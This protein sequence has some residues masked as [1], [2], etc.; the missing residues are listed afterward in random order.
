MTTIGNK[1]ENIIR[2]HINSFYWFS[3]KVGDY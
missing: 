2:L 1:L 3:G